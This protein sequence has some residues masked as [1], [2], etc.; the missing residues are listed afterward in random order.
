[1][2]IRDF[3]AVKYLERIL[4][5]PLTEEEINGKP[6]RYLFNGRV[7]VT[8]IAKVPLLWIHNKNNLNN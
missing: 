2:I 1:M 7:E 8:Q 6:I 4:K 5:R 3:I